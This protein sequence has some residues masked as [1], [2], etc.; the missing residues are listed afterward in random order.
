MYSMSLSSSCRV[1]L[2]LLAPMKNDTQPP[3]NSNELAT[4][5]VD[6]AGIRG[7]S[8]NHKEEEERFSLNG[9]EKHMMMAEGL[10]ISRIHFL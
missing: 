3:T 8:N 5:K 6:S 2:L 10:H 1:T 4:T 7:K 9:A